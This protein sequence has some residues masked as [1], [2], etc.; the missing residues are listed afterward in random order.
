MVRTLAPQARLLDTAKR[1]MLGGEYPD[2]NAHHAVL[3]RL[4][5]AE[6]AADVAAV[7][8]AGQAK[9]GVV[10]RVNGFLL[11]VE[12]EHRGEGAKGLFGGAEHVGAGVGQHRGLEELARA[13]GFEALAAS[14]QLAALGDGILNMALHLDQCGFFDQ[15]ALVHTLVKAIAHLG[16]GHLG[17]ELLHKFVVDPAL[18]VEPVGAHAGL[19]GVA[20]LAGKGAFNSAVDIGVVED[21]E[22]RV[23]AEFE[24][25][26]LDRGRGLRHQDAAD[27]GGAGKADVAHGGALAEH[28][29]NGNGV[30]GVGAEHVEHA[31]GDAGALGQFGGGQR[32][33]GGEFCGF[34]DHGAARGQGRRHLAGD[35]GEREVPGGDGCADANGLLQDQ[36]A[37]VV[38]ELRQGFAVDALGFFGKPLDEAGAIGDFAFGLGQGLALLGGHDA[39]EVVLIGHEQLEPFAQNAAALFGGF[40]APGGPGGIGSGYR[41]LGILR[42]EVGD[43][44]ELG[45]GG[46]VM[47]GEAAG[48]G[49]PLSVEEGVGL[50]EAGVFEG[51][52]GRG[53]L[54]HGRFRQDKRKR[55]K[56][57]FAVTRAVQT[58]KFQ[59]FR[60]L[61]LA[62]KA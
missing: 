40:A 59:C 10:G 34:D 44:G 16:R 36:Q 56:W 19:A 41:G 26:L 49:D 1:H 3:Q 29:A 42:A 21:D 60:P 11:G 25:H 43:F 8:V 23:A 28:F 9:L 62:G 24:R 37:L 52:E 27:F 61:A 18:H 31:C 12:P 7:E 47:D 2:V 4:A 35:H 15:R 33:E 5:H 58:Q 57:A 51:G 39:A 20:V 55:G 48:A 17:G 50:E 32:R 54:G 30:V 22:R 45:A 14:E 46:R 53:V 38:V 13:Q 6:D